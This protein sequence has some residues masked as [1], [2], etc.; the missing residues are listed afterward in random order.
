MAITEQHMTLE[1]FL[2][3]PEKKP[4]LEFEDGVVTQKVPPR[5]RHSRLQ[6]TVPGRINPSDGPSHL[7]VAFPELRTTYAGY[8]RVPDVSVYR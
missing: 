6:S 8:S 3:L 5:G 4:A 2:A 7:A 1:A